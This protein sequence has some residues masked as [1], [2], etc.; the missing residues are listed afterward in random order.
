MSACETLQIS[1]KAIKIS[2]DITSEVL[3]GMDTWKD[4]AIK[5]DGHKLFGAHFQAMVSNC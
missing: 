1:I 5:T 2:I 4:L 3:N